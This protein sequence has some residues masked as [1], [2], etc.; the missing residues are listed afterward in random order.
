MMIIGS[1]PAGLAAAIYAARAGLKPVIAAPPMGGQLQGK[2]V[3]VENYPVVTQ[4][5][6][7]TSTTV[8]IQASASRTT[9]SPHSLLAVLV[10]KYEDRC[11]RRE[12]PGRYTV[13]LLYWYTSTNTDTLVGG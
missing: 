2:G 13:H 12:L 3:G 4:F 5:T 7:F 8:Q 1:G 6:C 10:Q 11:R 9:R